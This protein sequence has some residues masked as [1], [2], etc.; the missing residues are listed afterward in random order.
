[1]GIQAIQA[2]SKRPLKGIAR[3]CRDRFE[4]QRDVHPSSARAQTCL[5]SCLVDSLNLHLVFE[6]MAK[7]FPCPVVVSEHRYDVAEP[8][9]LETKDVCLTV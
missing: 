6:L 5:C 3:C 1:M 2:A 4:S 8:M 7:V 9:H